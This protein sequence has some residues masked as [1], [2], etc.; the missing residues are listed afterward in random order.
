MM[1]WVT[2]MTKQKSQTINKFTG[3]IMRDCIT[4]I[5]GEHTSIF[6]QLGVDGCQDDAFEFN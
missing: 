3:E 1:I 2:V 5:E 4:S 6:T